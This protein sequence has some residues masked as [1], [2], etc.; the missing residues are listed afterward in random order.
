MDGFVMLIVLVFGSLSYGQDRKT[1]KDD[2]P[3]V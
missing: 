2:L 3:P 1:P